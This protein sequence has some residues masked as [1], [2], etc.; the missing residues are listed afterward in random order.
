MEIANNI[1]TNIINLYSNL[2]N[3]NQ[4]NNLI[5]NLSDNQILNIANEINSLFSD[6]DLID[7]KQ[8]IKLPRIVVVGTQSSGKSSVLN[9]IISMDIL[10]TGQN[11]VTRTPL[12]I[13]LHKLKKNSD[14]YIEFGKYNSNGWNS[15][16]KIG[17]HTP[18]PTEDEIYKI[19]EY[20]Q[21]K[22]NELAGNNMNISDIPIILNI[23]SSD[24]P[25]LSLV[26]L[27]GLTMVA[28]I[29]K[30]QP[31]DIK[32]RIENLVSTYIKDDKT[33]VLVVM[34]SRSD[35]ETDL[36][37]ALVK[38]HDNLGKR[39][40]G[41]LTKPDLM[42]QETH[43]GDYLINNNIS[44]NLM[45]S[46]GYYVVKNRTIKEMKDIDIIKSL[47]Y[48]KQYFQNHSEYKKS[49]YSHK[50]GISNLTNN[51][52]KILINSITEILPNVMSQ[53]FILEQKVNNKIQ[54]LGKGI[55]TTK[56]GKIA[57]LNKYI[58]NYSQILN[59]CIESKSNYNNSGKL[60]KDIF[61]KYRNDILK[62]DIVNNKLTDNYIKDI[63]SNYEG[64]HMTHSI[65]PILILETYILD[66]NLKPLNSFLQI[67][68]NCIE[69][70]CDMLIDTIKK[71]A[72]IDEFKCYPDLINYISNIIIED[73]IIKNKIITKQQIDNLIQLELEYIWTDNKKFIE[74][75][76]TNNYINNDFIRKLCNCYI[77]SIKEII[78]HLI[79]K[80]IMKNIIR[81]IEK[82]MNI[83][84]YNKIIHDDKINLLKEDDNIEQQRIYYNELKNKIDYIKKIN[85]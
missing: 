10:P 75:L 7:N 78:N 15:E 54:L 85:I 53:I 58:T 27:P 29:D 70:I 19:R 83:F 38:K 37:L 79:P 61:I 22:T 55:P 45:L 47:E 16:Y 39:T 42:N 23:Y 50:I 21:I 84:L 6:T 32:E 74:L 41:V 66:N 44:K 81:I 73:F 51:L 82:D 5:K 43:I 26:D 62:M 69:I 31:I 12:D 76:N 11:M 40:I 28:C 25:N 65:S 14:G 46:Y 60:I 17:I 24:V 57:L 36:G 33:I 34:H 71:I 20:I 80:I 72:L 67:S 64:N 4:L 1:S 8:E 13:R 3:Q 30:G 2:F 18:I 63:I 77:E 49:I 52:N 59:D 48:E 9:S 68:Y 56:E 35:L